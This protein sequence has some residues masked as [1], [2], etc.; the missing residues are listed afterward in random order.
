[1]LSAAVAFYPHEVDHIIAE[2]HD[3]ATEIDNL[4]CTCA[5]CNRFKGSDLGSFDPQTGQ[6]AFLFNPRA[7][8]WTEHFTFQGDLIVGLTATGRATV[9]ILQMN[10]AERIE[11]RRRAKE[12]S[13]A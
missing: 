1:L 2:K 12:I 7:Q 3:G 4:A 8:V 6:F 11:E 13:Q 9:K 10:T 5:R